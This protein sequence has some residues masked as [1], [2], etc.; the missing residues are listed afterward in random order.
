MRLADSLSNPG[1]PLL[2]LLKALERADREPKCQP[3]P[4]QDNPAVATTVRENRILS[5][6][7]VA[8]MVDAYRKGANVQELSRR[9]GVHRCTVDRHLKLS[10]T[11]K[12]PQLKMTPDRVARAEELYAQGWTMQRIGN[13]FNVS[14]S[15]VRMALKR[16][17]VRTRPPVA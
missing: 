10:G 13:E 3:E 7:E 8:E 14:A 6:E 16:A 4:D 1:A 5:P 9:Y 11:E 2:R 12:R 15:T 17:G